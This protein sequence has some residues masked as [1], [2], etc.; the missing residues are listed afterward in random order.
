MVVLSLVSFMSLTIYCFLSIF[1]GCPIC[2][3]LRS[4]MQAKEIWEGTAT[5][6]FNQLKEHTDEGTLVSRQRTYQDIHKNK[7]K[8]RKRIQ[9]AG[10]DRM[11]WTR[12]CG[13]P[14]KLK[15]KTIGLVRYLWVSYCHCWSMATW[16]NWVVDASRSSTL[17]YLASASNSRPR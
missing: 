14:N 9:I 10:H 1:Y 7:A 15:Y 3:A 11:K 5:P 17:V 16:S 6:L 12:K 2:F 13:T 4:F 8:L